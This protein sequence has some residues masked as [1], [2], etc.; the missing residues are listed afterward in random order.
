MP[1]DDAAPPVGTRRLVSIIV[2][3][4]NEAAN[5][6]GLV[7][8]FRELA[9]A[10]D[11][12]DFELV[13]IDDGSTDD[14]A[15]L[16]LEHADPA[17]RTVAVRLARRF[18][19]H[20]AI[21]AGLDECHGDSAIV[22][23][24]DL[25]EPPS[26]IDAFLADWESGSQVVWGVRRTRNAGRS[27]ST[28]IFSRSFSLLFTRYAQLQNYPAEGPSGVLVDRVVMDQLA[29]M[30]EHNRNVLALIAWLGFTQTRVE[31]DQIPRQHGESRWTRRR[32]L[33]LA[34]DSLIQFS[35]MPLRLCTFT[36]LAV[37][38]LGVLYALLLVVRVLFGV[39]TPPGWSTVLVVVLL[40]GG[41]Q[42]TVVGVMGEY[43]WRAVE[44]TRARPLFVVRDVRTAARLDGSSPRSG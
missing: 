37:A 39:D 14:T 43:L 10:H 5:V 33:Q 4:L 27:L 31:Y 40:L 18:G 36:G 13:L 17:Y 8:R 9:R 6:P 41:V 24:A 19:S 3:A 7:A 21:S 30:P 29:K 42:L 35:S 16:L 28:E 2:P 32:M 20:Y 44:E 23:G 11:R 15:D 34:V 1:Q 22:L 25:Q 12:Y 26:L 38:L